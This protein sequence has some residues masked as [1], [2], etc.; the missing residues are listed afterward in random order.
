MVDHLSVGTASHSVVLKENHINVIGPENLRAA[1]TLTAALHSSTLAECIGTYL[2]WL[3][4]AN[5]T[6]LNTSKLDFSASL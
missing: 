5:K 1:P 4:P 6:C 2:S 3:D